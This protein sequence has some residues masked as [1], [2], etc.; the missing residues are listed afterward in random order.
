MAGRAV[1]AFVVGLESPT[2][3]PSVAESIKR[4]FSCGFAGG[5]M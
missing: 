5:L 2:A 4:E 3:Q 1:V